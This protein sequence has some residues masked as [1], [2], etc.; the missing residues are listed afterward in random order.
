MG[1]DFPG[2]IVRMRRMQVERDGVVRKE[3]L[4]PLSHWGTA[5]GG[6]VLNK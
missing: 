5:V 3:N 1:M 6:E 2:G 4:E